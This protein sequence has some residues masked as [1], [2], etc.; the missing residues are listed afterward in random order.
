MVRRIASPN[1]RGSHDEIQIKIQGLHSLGRANYQQIEA[2]LAIGT[3]IT[4]LPRNG[5]DSS[6]PSD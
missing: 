4:T 5:T 3:L 1:F 6:K 2:S